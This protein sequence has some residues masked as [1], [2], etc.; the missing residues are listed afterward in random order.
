MKGSE[1]ISLGFLVIFT[2]VL[3]VLAGM[4]RETTK[5]GT[6]VRGG[7]VVMIGP[8]PIVFGT[9][10]GSI[11]ILIVLM[12]LLIFVASLAMRWWR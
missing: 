1:L 6:Q 4:F 10:I 12:I 8:I 7:G 11:K 5:G 9:D 3:L 2:G